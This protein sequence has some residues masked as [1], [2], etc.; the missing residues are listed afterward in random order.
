[1]SFKITPKGNFHHGNMD[2][3]CNSHVSDAMIDDV[4]TVDQEMS[5]YDAVQIMKKNNIGSV[6][7]LSAIFDAVGIFTER[8]LMNKI[9]AEGK[10]PGQV[11]VKDVMTPDFSCVQLEDS[12]CDIPKIMH[13]KKHAHIPVVKGREVV[14]ILSSDDI[15]DFLIRDK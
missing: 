7:V 12:L 6:V 8:D 5:V 13:D 4:K 3:S 10:D 15:L 2:I 1:M 11:K 9:V 14:G